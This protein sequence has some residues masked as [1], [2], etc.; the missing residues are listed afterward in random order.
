[1]L[2]LQYGILTYK[3]LLWYGREKLRDMNLS[4]KTLQDALEWHLMAGADEAFSDMPVNN[5]ISLM[6]EKPSAEPVT[7]SENKESVSETSYAVQITNKLAAGTENIEELKTAINSF[8]GI[9][10]KK[11]ATNLVFGVGHPQAEV[12]LV[13]EAPGADED[14]TGVPFVGASGRL[15]DKMFEA[16]GL[17]RN[18]EKGGEAIY[19]SNI[20][21]WRPPG[22]RNPT[23]KEIETCLPFIERH[24]ELVNPKILVLIGGVSAKALL[25]RSEGITRLRGKIHL[26]GEQ[27]IPA[28][29]TY[30]PSFLLRSPS[31]KREAWADLL[32]I[33]KKRIELGLV[34]AEK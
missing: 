27:K 8:E 16:I 1:L 15:L 7:V 33:Q 18:T 22:N 24:I 26:Y 13:G 32:F 30:H 21:N 10:I 28:I 6:Q 20:L 3:S 17:S 2:S 25:R 19:I 31:K 34:S 23:P 5:T 11:T 14:R 4:Q 29:A 12:M 9:A